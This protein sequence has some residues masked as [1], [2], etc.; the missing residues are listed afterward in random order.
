MNCA[1][2]IVNGIGEKGKKFLKYS[3]LN[4]TLSWMLIG[5]AT[6]TYVELYITITF[7]CKRTIMKQDMN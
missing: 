3:M 7:P 4:E 2:D 5:M 6:K 1:P